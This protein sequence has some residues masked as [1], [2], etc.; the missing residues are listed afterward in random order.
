MALKNQT[1]P[2]GRR[3]QQ[4]ELNAREYP[5][6]AWQHTGVHSS[7]RKRGGQRGWLTEEYAAERKKGPGHWVSFLEDHKSNIIKRQRKRNPQ[8]KRK[9]A[10]SHPLLRPCIMQYMLV[11]PGRRHPRGGT[12]PPSALG[13]RSQRRTSCPAMHCSPSHVQVH[14]IFS[15]RRKK[16]QLREKKLGEGRRKI[17]FHSEKKKRILKPEHQAMTCVKSMQFIF[18]Q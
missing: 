9:P 17:F 6:S 3:K 8:R 11:W 15:M 10:N 5:L 12:Q 13:Q 2:L 16:K 1:S 7:G 14:V 4:K 18:S